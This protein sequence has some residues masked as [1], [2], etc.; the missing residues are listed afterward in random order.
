MGLRSLRGL[1]DLSTVRERRERLSC[2]AVLSED[3]TVST[4]VLGLR[5]LV[6][7]GMICSRGR[8]LLLIVGEEILEADEG[9]KTPILMVSARE[10]GG[11]GVIGVKVAKYSAS[12]SPRMLCVEAL[13]RVSKPDNVGGLL[14]R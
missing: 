13:E 4:V 3:E 7:S 10:G 5:F 1:G 12:L 14:L 11:N 9:E 2:F 6:D 8:T